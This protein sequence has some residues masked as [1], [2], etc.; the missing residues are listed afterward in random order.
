MGVGDIWERFFFRGGISPAPRP[1]GDIP[2]P[3]AEGRGISSA[4]PR[5]EGGY[6]AGR[7]G[8]W[9]CV[10]GYLAGSFSRFGGYLCDRPFPNL[11][12]IAFCARIMLAA[13]G[14]GC[15]WAK[16]RAVL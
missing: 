11:P 2:H 1:R 8:S 15:Y 12:R 5:A 4:P 14:L 9:M 7:V 6:L 13:W 10:G 16:R 3:L